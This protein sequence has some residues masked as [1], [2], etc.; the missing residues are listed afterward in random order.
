MTSYGVKEA[1]EETNPTIVEIR[2]KK[3]EKIG[4]GMEA[5]PVTKLQYAS[6]YARVSNYWK[7]YIG[8]SKGLKRMNVMDKKLKIEQEFND[9]VLAGGDSRKDKYGNALNLIKE[10]YEDNKKINITEFSYYGFRNN[11]SE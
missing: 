7:Y 3:L 10:A 6:K 5:S 4:R 1:L 11:F 8:Q 2:D 9:W